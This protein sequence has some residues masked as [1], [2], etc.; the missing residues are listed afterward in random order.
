MKV[1]ILRDNHPESSEKWE[2]ACRKQGLDY[3]AIDM[4]RADWLDKINL[5]DP[6]FCVSR[7]PGDL[8]QNKKIF[9]EKLYHLENY[10]PYSVFPS[11]LETWIYENKASLAWFLATNSIPHPKIFVS[12]NYDES[13]EFIKR[14][15]YPVVAKTL[16]GAAGS[17]VKIFRSENKAQEYVKKA[18]KIGI[19]RRFGPNRKTSGPKDWFLKAMQSPQYFFKKV[20]QYRERS[21]DVQR[22]IVFFQKY[23]DHDFEWRCVKI[24]KSYFTY[25]KLKIGEQASGSKVFEYGPAPFELL[26]FTK[27][28]CAKFNFNF[29]AVDIFYNNEGIFVN[30]LQTIFGHKNP[31]ICMVDG[32]PGRYIYQNNRWIFE[33][34]DFNTNESFD[35]RLKT[36]V[37]LYEQNRL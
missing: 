16:I 20:S 33:P 35:L 4:L 5:F 26:D 24:G 22:G 3:M 2:S 9:D 21:K 23:C 36:A 7:P 30:E 32:K 27:D 31:Y 14:A 29:M 8:Q 18:F 6:G 37:E 15:E 19:R 28:L 25:K 10:T 12:S 1:A 34:G 13:M 17:G 11:F